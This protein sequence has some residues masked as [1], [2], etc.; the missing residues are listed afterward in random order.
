MLLLPPIKA[1]PPS[2]VVVLS[3]CS[4]LPASSPSTPSTVVPAPSTAPFPS[5]VP[6][7]LR[8]LMLQAKESRSTGRFGFV[9]PIPP[10][11]YCQHQTSTSLRTADYARYGLDKVLLWTVC[12]LINGQALQIW[13]LHRREQV[14]YSHDN[15][16]HVLGANTRTN[17]LRPG[18]IGSQLEHVAH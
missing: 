10:A 13:N 2:V 4:I 6:H 16:E 12:A 11:E 15:V 8:A 9:G 17:G 14:R 5:M 7:K 1:S 3:P 18:N